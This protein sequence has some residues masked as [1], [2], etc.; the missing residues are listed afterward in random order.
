MKHL[1]DK[2][3]AA[4]KEGVTYLL[5]D[6]DLPAVRQEVKR[7]RRGG[8]S[9]RELPVHDGKHSSV[10]GKRVRLILETGI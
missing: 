2:L 8:H 3:I 10:D 7:L 5:T 9:I 6:R 1:Y 4:G